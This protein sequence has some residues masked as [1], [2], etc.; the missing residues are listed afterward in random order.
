MQTNFKS[1]AAVQ[2]II[3][4]LF[5]ILAA[6]VSSIGQTVQRELERNKAEQWADTSGSSIHF[7][8]NKGQIEQTDGKPAPYVGYLL[9]RGNTC[10]YLLKS[11]GIAYQFNRMHYPDGYREL[12]AQTH[13]PGMLKR[14]DTLQKQVRLE[15]YRMDMQLLGAN[16]EV[17][18]VA[19]GKSSDYT[20][21]Y[22]HD[23][24]FVH[25]YKRLTYKDI[26]PGI[27]WVVYTTPEGG[28]KY[29]FIVHPFADPSQIKIAFS[30]QEE[31]Y[32]DENCNLIHGNRLGRFTEQAPI[33][34]QNGQQ[35]ASRFILNENVLS[36]ELEGY[37]PSLPLTIDPNR[38]WATYYGGTASS[39]GTYNANCATDKNGN[40]FLVGHTRS[41]TGI[42]T[43]G[44][45]QTT[46]SGSYDLFIV[47]FS[48]SGVRQWATYYG[49]SGDDRLTNCTTDDIG[50]I[51]II[52]YTSSSAGIA[53]VGSHQTLFGGVWDAFLVKFNTTGVRQWATYLG[54]SGDDR[55]SDCA[56]DAN[57]NV[58]LSGSTTS[59]SGIA[60]TGSH[61][62]T[63]AGI[64]DAFL[65]KFNSA[66]VR[67]W[68][69]YYGGSNGEDGFA[70]A[71]DGNGS[72]FIAGST[73]SA[74]GIA[75]AG[76]HQ[77]TL[78]GT[79]W[80]DAFL[81]KFNTSG[82]RQWATYYGGS[83]G[84]NGRSCVIDANGNVFLSGYT[85]SSSGIVTTGSHQSTYAGAGDAF[86]V[87][88]NSSGVRQWATYFGGSSNDR[89]RSCVADVFG[90]VYMAGSTESSSGISTTGVYQ[91]T[92]GGAVDAFLAKFNSSGVRQW[93]TYYGSSDWEEGFSC[94]SDSF[95]N[96]YLSGFTM[97]NSSLA[98]NGHQMIA[99]DT[100]DAFLVKF[101][102][103]LCSID[104][105]INFTTCI[106]RTLSSPL[107]HRSQGATGIGA[108]INLPP[109][110]SATFVSNVIFISGTPTASGTY[111]YRIPLTGSA[112]SN[113]EAKGRITVNANVINLS[114]PMGTDSQSVMVNTAIANIVYTTTGATGIGTPVNLPLGV[115]ASY[116]S[117]V[118]FISG[119]PTS[120]GTYRYSI[121]LTGGCDNGVASGTIHVT[122]PTKA[123]YLEQLHRPWFITPNPTSGRI[124]IQHPGRGLFELVDVTGKRIS[125]FSSADGQDITAELHLPAGVYVVR[126]ISSGTAQKIIVQ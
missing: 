24:L 20:H 89:I 62:S 94:A 37:D 101:K 54:G 39:L 100:A 23:A 99:Y 21:Y 59:S 115:S 108:P 36:F 6:Q 25:H 10:I 50:N 48:S 31:L 8:E 61:Q 98:Y 22:T 63:Y 14:L 58:F 18:I 80:A 123:Q 34:F 57:G 5:L 43:S 81:V 13:E 78:V 117:N 44:S 92:Y 12:L 65:A 109:G 103:E 84:D 118:L 11:G 42:S 51:F 64:G 114:S 120:A 125:S 102:S 113:I 52:G 15:T 111:N 105:G 26:Y 4:S 29:D 74:A 66:G 3:V 112:C 9:E 35:I 124:S 49:G 97:S 33:S 73:W 40:I 119:T 47:K 53:T 30:Y 116:V 32:L 107:T 60:T 70:C 83:E 69:T 106:N 90:N 110:L 67:Q 76:S 91:T 82:V 104:S 95:G 86:L 87:K 55:G 41:L 121:P 27:D 46:L 2:K 56:T 19:D 1:N 75:T 16:P 71:I 126:E 93:A 38:I 68:A 96:I 17:Q 85:L 45:H 122:S 88:F 79:T 7:T 28:L 77:S 72:V